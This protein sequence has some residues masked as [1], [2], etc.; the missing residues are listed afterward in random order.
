MATP[1]VSTGNF[2]E[3]LW[4]G[5]FIIWGEN[6]KEDELVFRKIFNV[7][8]SNQRYEKGQ[9]AVPTGLAK[10]KTE[11]QGITYDN[12]LHG[13]SV[14][15]VHSTYA[16][17]SQITKEMYTD[18]LYKVMNK[19]PKW[20]ARSM[21]QTE[22]TTHANV[23]NDGFTSTAGSP[24]G[25]SLFNASHPLTGGGTLSNVPSTFSDLTET[26]LA[27]ADIDIRRFTDDRTL[28]INV[29]PRTLVVPTELR[30]TAMK[31]LETRY[32]VDTANNAVN[33][34]FNMIPLQEWKYLTDVDAWFV[35]TDAED[36]LQSFER[37]AAAFERDN[38]FDTKNLRFSATKRWSEGY[39]DFRGCYGNSGGTS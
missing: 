5:L 1:I 8:K 15:F 29:N 32:E 6:Y 24:D 14:E 10:V 11:G 4:P 3:L 39:V 38:D 2:P 31:I 22:E 34:T 20:L 18:D 12:P 25:V 28:K 27:Q 26:S 9:Q 37:W 33:T 7:D 35:V 36:G 16:L 13:N 30:H 19:I 21:M 23:L 17:G